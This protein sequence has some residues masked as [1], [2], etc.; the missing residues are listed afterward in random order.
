MARTSSLKTYAA[1]RDFAHTPEPDATPKRRG[2]RK[3][4]RF[5]VQEHDATA[6]HWDLR[7]EHDG[8]LLSWAVPKGVPLAPKENRLAIRT[9][10]HPLEYLDFHGEIPEGSYGAG[11]MTIWDHGTFELEELALEEGKVHVNFDGERV[12]GRYMLVR[13]KGGKGEKEQWLLR[14]LDPADDPDRVPMPEHVKPMLAKLAELPG[15]T[16]EWAYE[17]K[18]DGIRAV[19][20]AEGGRIRIETRNQNDVTA[21]YPEL[22]RFGRVLGSHDAVIDGEIVA[23]DDEGRPS[24][25]VLQSRLGLTAEATIKARAKATPVR[26]LAFDLLHLDGHDLRALPYLERRQRLRELFKDDPSWQV[27][28][29]HVGAGE[30]LLAAVVEQGLEG[31]MAKRVDSPYRENSRAGAWLKV[32]QQQRQEFVICGWTEGDGRRRGSIGALLLAY[33]DSTPAQAKRRK[34]P[35]QLV[36]AGSVGT[37]FSDAALSKLAKQ[38]TPDEITDSPLD[39]GA[40][41]PE[42]PGKWKTIRARDRAKQAGLDPKLTKAK[43]QRVHFVEPR[44]VCEVEFTEF[45]RDG[46]LRHPSYKGLRDDK[47]PTDVIREDAVRKRVTR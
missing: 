20:F 25:Q 39:V 34:R 2:R 41:D 15:D 22:T 18:W 37:G 32:K 16:D 35:Q 31:V 40:P 28:A 12:H 19:V 13:T 43:A 5:V 30:A 46:T 38:L 1:K 4:P 42:S 17:V 10:D 24:F 45:T 3:H 29:H 23:F 36:Y 47:A 44:L 8:V 6:M 26:Y 9:E 14:R 21:M 27:P 33:Y 11:R 7:L